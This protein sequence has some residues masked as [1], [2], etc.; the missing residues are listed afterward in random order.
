[1]LNITTRV[2]SEEQRKYFLTDTL[3]PIDPYNNDLYMPLKTYIEHETTF[4]LLH[5]GQ[6]LQACSKSCM[7]LDND[8]HNWNLCTLN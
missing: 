6:A 4:E 8:L 5:N 2:L 1:M 3:Q 7:P